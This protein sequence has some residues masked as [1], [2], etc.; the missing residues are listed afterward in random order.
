MLEAASNTSGHD[1][2]TEFNG[3]VLRV[4]AKETE[5]FPASLGSKERTDCRDKPSLVNEGGLRI[6]GNT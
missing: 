6:E 3:N 2:T 5:I 1:P 4:R